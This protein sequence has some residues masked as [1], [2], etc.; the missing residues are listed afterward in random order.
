MA[1]MC[2]AA[3][4]QQAHIDCLASSGGVRFGFSLI[5]MMVVIAV[6]TIILAIALP[7]ISM[8]RTAAHRS[9]CA[10]NQRQVGI[11]AG[12]Y[13]ADY[14]GF[15]GQAGALD[16]RTATLI[17]N[18]ETLPE[19]FTQK[20]LTNPL[21][22]QGDHYLALGYLPLGRTYQDK[23]GSA[24]LLCP[25]VRRRF[26]SIDPQYHQGVGNVES[27]I[28]FS[29]LLNR[30]TK[31]ES[32]RQIR[33]NIWGPYRIG[34]IKRPNATYLAGDAVARVDESSSRHAAMID[35]FNWETVGETSTVFGVTTRPSST[36]ADEQPSHHPGG[37]NGLHFDGHV[38]TVKQPGVSERFLLRPYFTADATG[39]YRTPTGL[40]P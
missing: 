27:H 1:R 3:P 18:G 31:L 19:S 28:F 15:Y 26:H 14:R 12:L 32:Y 30:P 7:A 6:I 39:E 33:N 38:E 2:T 16:Y 34:Q 20:G 24:M 10:S 35:V 17:N 22:R 8:A 40:A 21:T 25:G 36:W 4:V 37:P 9:Q 13:G 5:E 23:P 29:T 11:V